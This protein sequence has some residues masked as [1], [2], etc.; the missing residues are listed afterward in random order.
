[1]PLLLKNAGK[2]CVKWPVAQLTQIRD[3]HPVHALATHHL[4]MLAVADVTAEGAC[5]SLP[6][7]LVARLPDWG[8]APQWCFCAPAIALAGLSGFA[9]R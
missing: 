3:P 2:P 6:L 8:D 7:Y 5:A 1:M 9:A 4:G